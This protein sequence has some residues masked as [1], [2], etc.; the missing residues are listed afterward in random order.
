[1]KLHI[2]FNSLAT[3]TWLICSCLKPP[4]SKGDPVNMKV[5]AKEP[6]QRPS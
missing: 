1:M 3:K 5:F 4:S 6:V 2:M